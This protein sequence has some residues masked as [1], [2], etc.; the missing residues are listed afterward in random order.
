M[1]NTKKELG[2]YFLP[3][4]YDNAPGRPRLNVVLSATPTG[5]HFDPENVIYPIA[6]VANRDR[7]I[8][9][10]IVHHNWLGKKTYRVCAGFVRLTDRRGK[11]VEAYSFGG[12]LQINAGRDK[13]IAKLT[14]CAPI[15]ELSQV[16]RHYMAD[17][18]ATEAEVL[19]ARRRATWIRRDLADYERRLAAVAPEVLYRSCIEAL[20]DRFQHCPPD[21]DINTINAFRHFLTAESKYLAQQESGPY[22]LLEDI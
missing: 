15:L 17:V 12:D 3:K 10:L 6:A 19:L 18:L 11:S 21:G 13:T 14:S 5:E 8:E 16:R 1:T 20:K 2:Y 7:G 4:Q 22:R 9:H